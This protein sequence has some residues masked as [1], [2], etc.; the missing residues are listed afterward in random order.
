MRNAYKIWLGK[1]ERTGEQ[2]RSKRRLED[3]I[4]MDLRKIGWV[5]TGFIWPR[6]GT[7]GGCCEHDNEP[8]GSIKGGEFID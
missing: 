6:I 7:I 3:N 4:R 5:W 1:P 8:S 2:G